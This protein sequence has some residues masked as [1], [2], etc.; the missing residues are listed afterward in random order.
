M[1]PM[2]GDDENYQTTQ[3][4]NMQPLQPKFN[5][6]WLAEP[7]RCFNTSCY[8]IQFDLEKRQQMQSTQMSNSSVENVQ[9]QRRL[10][11]PKKM[12]PVM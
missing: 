2:C 4:S 8:K 11:K 5:H 6:M 3:S 12:Q 1:R 7:A 9:S 10:M